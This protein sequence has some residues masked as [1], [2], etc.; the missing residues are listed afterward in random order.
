MISSAKASV[1][2][3][4]GSEP[5]TSSSQED[6]AE[7]CLFC[8]FYLSPGTWEAP[9]H[10]LDQLHPLTSC[11]YNCQVPQHSREGKHLTL[12]EG[13]SWRRAPSAGEVEA[14]IERFTCSAW[15]PTWSPKGL[16]PGGTFRPCERGADRGP[17]VGQEG[18]W[19]GP[20]SGGGRWVRVSR[21]GRDLLWGLKGLALGTVRPNLSRAGSASSGAAASL[22]PVTQALSTRRSFEGRRENPVSGWTASGCSLGR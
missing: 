11:S 5:S 2:S 6:G 16:R 9:T 3:S 14:F 17:T 10:P 1:P 13:P 21:P 15:S 12:R 4:A 22:P 18:R 19:L 8:P 20:F 7:G